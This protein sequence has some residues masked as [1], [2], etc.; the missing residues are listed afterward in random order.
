MLQVGAT[1][2][3]EEEDSF[4]NYE[5]MLNYLNFKLLY[6]VDKILTLY[7]L[8][9]VSRTKLTVVLLWILLVSV[10]PLSRLEIFPP[11]TSVMSQDLALQQ[12]AS[13]LHTSADPWTFSTN[14]SSLLRIHFPLLNP[15]GLHYYRV[16]CVVLLPSIKF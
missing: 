1:G 8:L 6:S 14:I 11:L 16:T 2:K 3:E 15:T 9:T 12:G 4:C 5:S 13:R 10:Y 7:F